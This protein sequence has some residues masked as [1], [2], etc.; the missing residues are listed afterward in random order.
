MLFV[1]LKT[2]FDILEEICDLNIIIQ[3]EGRR[4]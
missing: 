1:L 4:Q 3:V 2:G